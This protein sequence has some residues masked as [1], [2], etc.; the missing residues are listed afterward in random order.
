MVNSEPD[1]QA[2]LRQL[3]KLQAQRGAAVFIV[4]MVLTLLTAVGIFAVRSASMADVA[5]GYDR[6]G[7]QATL[8]AQYGIVS[9]AAYMATGVADTIVRTMHMPPGS[10]YKQPTCESNAYPIPAPSPPGNPECYRIYQTEIQNSFTASSNETV[11]APANLA[12]SITGSTSSLN[13]NEITDATF[14]VELTDAS[15]SAVP[16]PGGGVGTELVLTSIAQVRPIAACAAGLP[17]PNAGQA[18][19]RAIITAVSPPSK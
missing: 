12:G 9:T 11:F 14:I 16:M 3:R 7:A 5:A 18:V 15:T 8:V 2:K 17:V 19:V 6:E 1:W 4:V 13:A 10:S